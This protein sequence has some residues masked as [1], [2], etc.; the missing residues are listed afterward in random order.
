MPTEVGKILAEGAE[1]TV[2]DVVV[3]VATALTASVTIT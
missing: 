3:D 1:F 2:T